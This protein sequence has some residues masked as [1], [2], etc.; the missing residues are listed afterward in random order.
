MADACPCMTPAGDW[1]PLLLLPSASRAASLLS[2]AEGV[3]VSVGA[4]PWGVSDG[5]RLAGAPCRAASDRVAD[6]P[7]RA[8]SD[9]GCGAGSE[10]PA[11][12][13]RAAATVD[14]AGTVTREPAAA[15]P[16]AL[17][18]PVPTSV[19]GAAPATRADASG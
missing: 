3:V 10:G 1:L 2:T 4:L 16:G 19:D 11:P 7:C 14:S 5:A 13:D 9:R 18:T 6:A 12:A 15:A 17:T 8:A